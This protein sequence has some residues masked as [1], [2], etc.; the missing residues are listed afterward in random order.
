MVRLVVRSNRYQRNAKKSTYRMDDMNPGGTAP[1]PGAPVPGA[2]PTPPMP[3]G[4]PQTPPAPG[5]M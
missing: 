1:A 3:G 2:T 5:Q 4:A